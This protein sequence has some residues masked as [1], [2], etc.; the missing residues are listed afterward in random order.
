M[1]SFRKAFCRHLTLGILLA[2]LCN[3]QLVQFRGPDGGL[4]YDPPTQ[5]LRGIAGLIGAARL[6]DAILENVEWASIAPNGKTALYRKG[7]QMLA[8]TSAGLMEEVRQAPVEDPEEVLWGK[9]SQSAVLVW[10]KAKRTQKI[11]IDAV[12]AISSQEPHGLDLDGEI[13]AVAGTVETRMYVAVSGRGVYLVDAQTGGN[14]MLLPLASCRVLASNAEGTGIWAIDGDRG[15]LLRIAVDDGQ[16]AVFTTDPERLKGVTRLGVL[17]NEKELLLANPE[18]RTLYL[19]TADNRTLAE[20]S[21]LEAPVTHLSP[22][23][24]E[25]LLLLSYRAT[26][27]QSIQLYDALRGDIFFV[28]Y[29]GAEQ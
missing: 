11:E 24:R 28:P 6:G 17:S 3:G 15:V 21:A 29:L 19:Y 9:G 5:S 7:G 8:L 12:G 27:A 10:T 18:T 14:K 20:V 26:N 1:T 4:V 2:T 22:L 16:S 25:T 23:G 13:T